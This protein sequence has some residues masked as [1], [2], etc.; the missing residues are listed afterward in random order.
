MS[1]V[2]R[3]LFLC[4]IL[5]IWEVTTSCSRDDGCYGYWEGDGLQRGTIEKN[6][7]YVHPYRQCVE[8][9]PPHK[10]IWKRRR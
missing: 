4:L 3:I 9:V 7:F 10:N 8:E 2:K 6:K 5:V 1:L